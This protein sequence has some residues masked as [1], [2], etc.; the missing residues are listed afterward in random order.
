MDD[1]VNLISDSRVLEYYT[2]LAT[3]Y[4]DMVQKRDKRL[5]RLEVRKMTTQKPTMTD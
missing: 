2:H 5:I 4:Y 1:K 3:Q